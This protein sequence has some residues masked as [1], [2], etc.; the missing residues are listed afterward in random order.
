MNSEEHKI[1]NVVFA[2]RASNFGKNFPLFCLTPAHSKTSNG[3]FSMLM[4][5]NN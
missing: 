5:K 4:I 1:S 2:S 3:L